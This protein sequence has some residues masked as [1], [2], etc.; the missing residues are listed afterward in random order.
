[1]ESTEITNAPK[2]RGRPCKG[3]Q[4]QLKRP[5][6]HKMQIELTVRAT[7]RLDDLVRRTGASSRAEVVRRALEV[8]DHAVS[9]HE[10]GGGC[11]IV[12]GNGKT[13]RIFMPF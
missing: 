8:Y 12:Q 11:D 13:A 6:N 9:A 10:S 3:E 5:A 2:K 7:E 4:R 1:M